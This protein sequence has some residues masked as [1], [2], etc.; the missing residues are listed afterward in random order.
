MLRIE[1]G[2][3]L[4]RSVTSLRFL[5]DY[6]SSMKRSQEEKL[7]KFA[8]SSACKT[9]LNRRFDAK[10]SRRTWTRA[11]HL[12]D[13]ELQLM[14]KCEFVASMHFHLRAFYIRGMAKACQWNPKK[15]WCMYG[16]TSTENHCYAAVQAVTRL[17]RS[18]TSG[19]L[20]ILWAAP[21]SITLLKMSCCC[22]FPTWAFYVKQVAGGITEFL[23]IF[24]VLVFVAYVGKIW[25]HFYHCTCTVA[26]LLIRGC[27]SP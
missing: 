27:S 17:T 20:L 5:T 9:T 26:L 19:I 24:S 18:V 25:S 23:A 7:Y 1:W 13:L 21:S 10:I 12:P 8:Q 3:W 6:N 4:N 14:W 11:Y 2:R 22:I 15:S 16:D